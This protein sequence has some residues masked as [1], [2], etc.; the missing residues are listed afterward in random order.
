MGFMWFGTQNGLNRYDGYRFVIYRNDPKDPF[1]LSNN[2]ITSLELDREGH[3][4]V[5]TWGG[6]VNRL[7]QERSRFIRYTHDARSNSLSD[8]FVSCLSADHAG[9]LWIGTESGGLNRMSP[10]GRHFSCYSP[11]PNKAGSLNDNHVTDILEDRRHR[12]WVSTFQSGIS[13]FNASTGMFQPFLHDGHDQN[14]LSCNAVTSLL[15]DGQGRVWVGTYG[16]GLDCREPGENVFRHFRSEPANP[17][18]LPLNELL[19]L[20]EDGEGN[21][22]A[23][24]ENGGI[25]MLDPRSGLFR[26]YAQDDVDNTSLSNNSIYSLY[27]DHNNN[28]WVG[29]YSGGINLCNWDNTRFTHYRHSSKASSLSNNS[30]LCF[31]ENECGQVWIGTDGGGLNLFDPATGNFTH[32]RHEPGKPGT[33]S[34]DYVTSL[35]FD[36]RGYLWAGTV[37]YGVNVFDQHHTLIRT[38][39]ND[40]V[41]STGLK[42]NIIE[43]IVRDKDGD[44]WVASYGAGLN[45]YDAEKKTFRFYNREKG[46]L[47]SNNIQ[48]LLPD[49]RNRI[50]VGTFDKG[51]NVLDKKTGAIRHI[52]HNSDRDSL[53]NNTINCLLEDSQGKIWIGTA[54]GLDCWNDRSGKFSSFFIR[55]GLPD[56]NIVGILQDK[57][58]NIWVSTLNGI[59]RINQGLPSFT[60]YSMADGLQ[61]DDFKLHST[62]RSCNGTLYFGGTKGFNVIDPDR[63]RENRW[64]P[65]LVMTGFELFTREAPIARNE[66][67]PSPLKQNIAF[68][69]KIVLPYSYSIVSFEFASLNY[70]LPLKKEYAYKLHGFDKEWNDSEVV[71]TATYT[72]LDPGTYTFEVRGKNNS[73]EWSERTASLTLVILPPWWQTWWFRLCVIIFLA[74]SLYS[75]YRIRMRHIKNQR[76]TL[77]NLVEER[78]WQAESANRAK[79][80]FLATMSHEIRTPLNGVIG[81]STLLSQ[82]KM[83]EEQGEYVTTIRSCG[84][85]L[86]SV[87]NDILDFSKVEAGSMELDPR[88]FSLRQCIEDILDV[89]SDRAANTGIELV[90]EI[91]P[92]VPE[93]IRSDDIRLRQVLMNLVGNA[94]KFTHEGEIYIGVR[95]LKRPEE[96]EILLEFEVRDTGIGIPAGKVQRL[97]KAFSQA[98]SSTTRKYGGTGLGLAISEKLIRLMKGEIRVES[99]EG[100]GTAFLFYIRAEIGQPTEITDL[101]PAV[102][103]IK[104]KKVLVVDDNPV[105]RTLLN[106][107]LLQ[108]NLRPL[109][110]GSGAEALDL[111]KTHRVDLLIT[112]LHM[113]GMNGVALAE[114]VKKMDGELPIMLLSAIGNEG[115][116]KY[117][118]LFQATMH[119]P[120]KHHLLLRHIM[121]LLQGAGHSSDPETPPS[122]MLS[123]TFAGDHPMKILIAEDNQVNQHLMT[124]VLQKLGYS[125]EIAENGQEAVER[126]TIEHFDLV[127]MDVQMPVMDGLEATRLIRRHLPGK[128]AIIAL[129]ADAQEEDRQLCLAAGMDDY[130][131]KPMQLDKLMDILKKWAPHRIAS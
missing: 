61:D 126:L 40:P 94:I 68:A 10:D 83:T 80:A 53:S 64:D 48:C 56:N 37:G 58:G 110:A 59:S 5:G 49:S 90:Y 131:S 54:S 18:S 111:L 104:G 79:S 14:S 85:S 121:R 44:M 119:K 129:T 67:D 116:G 127:L 27:R 73:G 47:S 31:L 55:D 1:S 32:L 117:T 118:T 25:S 102:A 22:W 60:N 92:D 65:P 24:T 89:F 38:F 17:H 35:A 11:D 130:L 41:D 86:M 42:G 13:L 57:K 33:I 77:E 6:G 16:G 7:D 26:T 128:T 76:V 91:S 115:R 3:L 8:D 29:T 78:T 19:S 114:R 34:S 81:M 51:L 28:M 101:P 84:E 109:L 71:H 99:Q 43:S 45:C 124:H 50:W 4:W 75:A 70:T 74:G 95:L 100:R 46:F 105:N 103:H 122:Q 21:I 9:N 82:T 39:R 52:S 23:G 93:H 62:L 120:V 123:T 96:K 72:N 12:I 30:V 2:Y 87:I 125:P 107:L 88:D 98:D 36:D 113:P 97:F 108:W 20:G 66:D 112:D 63:I 69:R 15:E 106:S